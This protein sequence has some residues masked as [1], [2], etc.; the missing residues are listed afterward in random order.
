MKDLVHHPFFLSSLDKLLQ[1]ARRRPESIEGTASGWQQRRPAKR[2]FGVISHSGFSAS[3]TKDE[4][5]ARHQVVIARA[6]PPVAIWW[7]R[8]DDLAGD[9]WNE[10][11]LF[12]HIHPTGLLRSETRSQ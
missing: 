8:G 11:A 10:K 12:G 2:I 6:S 1:Q 5:R 7:G 4:K 9:S 3:T